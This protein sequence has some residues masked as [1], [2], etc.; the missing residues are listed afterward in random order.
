MLLYNAIKP[1]KRALVITIVSK[2]HAPAFQPKGLVYSG[3]TVVFAISDC[4][5]FS[6]I[7][8][9][10]HEQWAW[11]YSSTLKNDRSYTPSSAFLTFPFPRPTPSQAAELERIG[12]EYDAARRALMLALD[13][14]L[15]D[16]YNLFHDPGVGHRLSVEEFGLSDEALQQL[17]YRMH[18]QRSTP[19]GHPLP[20]TA[21]KGSAFKGAAQLRMYVTAQL[22]A[23]HKAQ[24]ETSPPPSEAK[25]KESYQRFA[26]DIEAFRDLHVSMDY[27][28]AA[29]YGW[30][31]LDRGN[32]HNLAFD[33][34]FHDQDY[35]PE[36]DRLR[37]TVSPPVRMELLQ[38]LL[39]L[40]FERFAEEGKAG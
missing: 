19:P 12:G 28:V 24:T 23:A 31:G 1:L 14:G 16:L 33:H 29:A 11:K 13:I 35:L 25:I 36:N 2:T 18:M 15:T 30:A 4:C 10:F 34:G 9:N 7:Q 38:R 26:R 6:I 32:P 5:R 21:Y 8:S 39:L 27:A 20:P 40:N 37:Y 22:E 17:V 3:K